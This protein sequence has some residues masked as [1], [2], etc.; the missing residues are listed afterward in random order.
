MSDTATRLDPR[1]EAM[2]DYYN[3]RAPKQRVYHLVGDGLTP[4]VIAVALAK[5]SRSPQ[6]FDVNA[7]LVTEEGAA[8]FHDKWVLDYGHASVAEGAT[9][10]VCIEKVSMLAAKAVEDSRLGSYCEASTRYQIW[11]RNNF[12]VPPELNKPGREKL[13]SE[14]IARCYDLMSGYDQLSQRLFVELSKRIERP[15]DMTEAGFAKNLNAKACDIARGMLPASSV[16]MLAMVANARTFAHAVR[17]LTS[18]ELLEMHCIGAQMLGP[19][20]KQ[21]PTLMKYAKPND[22]LMRNRET[23]QSLAA[24]LATPSRS[25]FNFG[26]EMVFIE[27][28][29][30]DEAHLVAIT[31]ALYPHTDMGYGEIMSRVARLDELQV[32]AAYNAIF[33]G[34][35][36][37]D[38][39][40]RALEDCPI[41]FEV[42]CD[43]GTWRDLQRHRMQT[44]LNQLLTPDLGYHTP[45]EILDFGLMAAWQAVET[46]R[47]DHADGVYERMRDECGPAV[48]QYV[49]PMAY[50]MR[51]LFKMNTRELF[52]MVELRSKPGGHINYRRLVTEMFQ[53]VQRVNPL[54][55]ST[56]RIHPINDGDMLK[57]LKDK[58]EGAQ[59]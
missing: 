24:A 5:T 45:S 59:A 30:L 46:R 28:R 56:L 9:G 25:P 13:K 36:E 16:T 4:E 6:S 49:V 21:F 14:Y 34:R 3:A 18:H 48:A 20:T 58:P 7:G 17:K 22:Y 43:F 31:Q 27:P 2:F 55:V 32:K 38:Q 12:M 52:S 8:K 41:G 11:D 57:R 47:S 10:H 37:H 40:P 19:L 33:E 42:I 29:P 44:Q 15:A 54:L 39:T 1:D 50:R 35:G 23:M 51:A 26:P 53:E